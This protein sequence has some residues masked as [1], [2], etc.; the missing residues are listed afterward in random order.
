MNY[1]IYNDERKNTRIIIF[2]TGS[3]VTTIL[4]NSSLIRIKSI[5]NIT[6]TSCHDG[7]PKRV[8]SGFT[9]STLTFPLLNIEL[10]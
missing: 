5:L 2:Q 10:C 7:A 8:V 4:V 9:P 6:E 3:F 1:I